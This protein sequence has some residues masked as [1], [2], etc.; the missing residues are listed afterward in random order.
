MS[1]GVHGDA[2]NSIDVSTPSPAWI[3]P[4]VADENTA[5]SL[6]FS[7]DSVQTKFEGKDLFVSIAVL[8]SVAPDE[9]N[10]SLALVKVIG[11]KKYA[12]FEA[13]SGV[14]WLP[15]GIGFF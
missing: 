2:N 9:S 7:V 10:S 14:T 1:L 12:V 8:S 4:L 15:I 13:W 11:G 5:P 6:F 3:V